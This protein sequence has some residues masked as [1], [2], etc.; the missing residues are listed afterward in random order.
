VLVTNEHAD[1]GGKMLTVADETSGVAK[2][3]SVIVTAI[4][5]DEIAI[6]AN[7]GVNKIERIL[8]FV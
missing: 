5:N 4:S 1:E 7:S 6:P 8:V 2:T 3:C